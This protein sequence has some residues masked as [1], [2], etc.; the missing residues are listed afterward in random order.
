MAV[1]GIINKEF[2]HIIRDYRT[3]MILF[4]MPVIQMIMFGYA[5]NMEI[6]KVELSIDDQDHSY[7]SRQLIRSFQGS[8]FFSI[9]DNEDKNPEEQ[10]FARKI[11]SHITIPSDFSSKINQKQ[12][13]SIDV[14]IDGSNSNEALIIEQYFMQVLNQFLSR[15]GMSQ[16]IPIQIY[17]VYRYNPELRSSY[18]MV[19]GLLALIMIMIT[20]LLTS[21]TLVRE[22]ETG[23]IT[24]LKISP[25]HSIEIIIGKVVPYLILSLLIAT[26]IMIVGIVLFKTPVK[27]SILLI[28]LFLLLYCITGL[29]FGMMISSLA[30]TQQVAMLAALMTTILPT[31]I[32]SGF[33]F[34]LESMPRVLQWI[35]H[36]I[37]AKYFLVIIRGLMIKNNSFMELWQPAAALTG[38]SMFFL[39]VS[40]KKFKQ[41]LEQ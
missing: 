31:L 15:E 27:G 14:M 5:L 41:F 18:L 28:Y 29:S 1:L 20:A 8:H 2:Y 32:L 25:L 39:M 11:R 35:S 13:T 37:P 17:P 38:F 7:Y 21:I 19:P 26:L 22:K 6:Q 3:L 34:P 16:K 9:I 4:L 10:F 23:T 36:I 24:L 40:T 30:K 12:M 33:M